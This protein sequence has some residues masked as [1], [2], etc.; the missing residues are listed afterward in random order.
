M[1]GYNMTTPRERELQES[2]KTV[3]ME[4]LKQE[5]I[6]ERWEMTAI[7]LVHRLE[8]IQEGRHT[9]DETLLW[10]QRALNQIGI[11]KRILDGE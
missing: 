11:L 3:K 1:T 2:L 5:Y 8:R 7:E 10:A 4:F 9:V 6:S